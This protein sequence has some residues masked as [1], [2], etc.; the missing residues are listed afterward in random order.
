MNKPRVCKV[1]RSYSS[2][3]LLTLVPRGNF[4]LTVCFELFQ[5][6]Y[7]SII[8]GH[9]NTHTV[10]FC[11]L[12]NKHAVQLPCASCRFFHLSVYGSNLSMSLLASHVP[13][14]SFMMI[15]YEY[16]ILYPLNHR[17]VGIYLPATI[18][19]IPK[20]RCGECP[21]SYPSLT[22]QFHLTS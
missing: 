17:L 9:T 3:F 20:Q 7:A 8:Y 10:L 19:R 2:L 6:F 16:I 5:I 18:L 11:V 1:N 15:S 14:S 12:F 13:S 21:H 22:V 4:L